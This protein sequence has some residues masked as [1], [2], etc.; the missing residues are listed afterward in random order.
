M[1]VETVRET[2]CK[3]P[4]D[5]EERRLRAEPGASAESSPIIRAASTPTAIPGCPA[6]ADGE[7]GSPTSPAPTPAPSPSPDP[8]PCPRFDPAPAK[9]LTRRFERPGGRALMSDAAK[10]GSDPYP[11]PGA[12]GP[13]ARVAAP[14]IEAAPARESARGED[15]PLARLIRLISGMLPGT[16]CR[17]CGRRGAELVADAAHA[18]PPP[19]A[20]SE[21]SKGPAVEEDE[22]GWAGRVGAWA[23]I[24]LS[25]ACPLAPEG[26]EADAPPAEDVNDPSN[27]KPP[28][29]GP[30]DAEEKEGGAPRVVDAAADEV[31]PTAKGKDES[32][33]M[34]VTGVLHWPAGAVRLLSLPSSSCSSIS[35][36]DRPGR[37]SVRVCKSCEVECGSRNRA[38]P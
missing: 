11:A 38:T 34:G 4:V 3:A 30:I 26:S 36:A 24:R 29:K 6:N 5:E 2:S 21:V 23:R 14:V 7:R 33:N 8:T 25:Y 16:R 18:D 10:R 35:A 20:P 27:P 9:L 17:P 37:G 13:L 12:P 22:A 1:G 32:M 28:E 31:G 15:D 19:A